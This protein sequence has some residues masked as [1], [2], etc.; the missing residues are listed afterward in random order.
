MKILLTAHQFFPAFKAGTEV[1][2]LSVARE[3]IKRGH[4]VRILTGNPSDSALTDDERFDEYHVEGVH[5]YR[6][7]HAYVP[8]GGQNSLIEIG[9]NSELSAR[10][11]DCVLAD[12]SP[13]IVHFF[14]LNRLGTGLIDRCVKM[15]V[16]CFMTPTDF[17]S[18]CPTGQL[19]LSDNSLCAGPSKN[20]G[21]CL[22]HFAES[23]ENNVIARVGRV[24][25]VV[26]ADSLVWLTSRGLL[27]SYPKHKEVSAL[28]NRLPT[29]VSRLNKLSGIIAPNNFMKGA[30]VKYGVNAD[31]IDVISFGID[32]SEPKLRNS[33]SRSNSALRIGFIG[34]L[35][36]HKG[37]DV[38]IRAFLA[39]GDAQAVL[40]VYG[41]PDDFPAYFESLKKMALADCRIH[42]CGTFPNFE[43]SRIFEGIDVL[44][45][46]S[47][48]YENNPLVLYSAHS[49]GCP[50]VAS[51]LAGLSDVVCD[52]S[53]GLLFEAGNSSA[54]TNILLRLSQEDGLLERLTEAVPSP[55]SIS[56]YVD[57]LEEVWQ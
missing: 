10:Y 14:H 15:G 55:K 24:L 39:F 48:W 52:D 8:M 4:L 26:G 51:N 2:T 1:L 47:V 34:T 16:P 29:N 38:L 9:Y 20:A 13:D 25:P 44:V 30:L 41:A 11:F 27:P 32:L 40:K 45:V 7:H 33:R 57:E 37:C 18:I 31:L 36:P 17:W 12:F 21:N 56:V 19:L 49:A 28:A 50:V 3:L 53:D 46:P 54:L 23:I 43:I 22:K 6:F 42:F 35:A 5:V